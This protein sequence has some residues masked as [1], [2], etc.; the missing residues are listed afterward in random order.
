MTWG[1]IPSETIFATMCSICSVVASDFI[2]TITVSRPPRLMSALAWADVRPPT[3]SVAL[4]KAGFAIQ[5]SRFEIRDS[6]FEIKENGKG[7]NSL[8]S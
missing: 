6:R 5:D 2:T 8:I 7:R 4:R 3:D 1:V